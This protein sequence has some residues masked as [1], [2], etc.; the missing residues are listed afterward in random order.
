[1]IPHLGSAKSWGEKDAGENR[2]LTPIM[3][4][5]GGVLC[6]VTLLKASRLQSLSAHSCALGETLD[7]SLLDLTLVAPSVSLSCMGASCWDHAGWWRQE[8]EWFEST[9]SMTSGL[10]GV[11]H[12]GLGDRHV[13]MDSRRAGAPPDVVAALMAGLMRRF[14]SV[15]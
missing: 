8:V 11:V 4:S 1:M 14:T 6:D 13:M 3:A 7:S 5:D 2:G 10:R 12:R 9:M 15:W